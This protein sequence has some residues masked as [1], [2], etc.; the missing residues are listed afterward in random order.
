VVEHGQY[1]ALRH[2]TPLK[3]WKQPVDGDL[4]CGYRI[5]YDLDGDCDPQQCDHYVTMDCGHIRVAPEGS[6]VRVRTVKLWHIAGTWSL[7]ASWLVPLMGWDE[8]TGEF[9][10]NAAALTGPV[11]PFELSDPTALLR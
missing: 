7:L 5:D 4:A 10:R 11:A 2:R 8:I 6:G 3:F 1:G 9:F